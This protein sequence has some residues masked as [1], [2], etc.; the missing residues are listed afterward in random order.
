YEPDVIVLLSDGA[1]NVGPLPLDAAQQAVERGI[2]V[3]TIGFGTEGGG[4]MDCG[5]Q[6]QEGDL[7]GGGQG[8]GGGWGS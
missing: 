3:Y 1:S 4:V 6:F 7:F 2:R 5:P 8:F